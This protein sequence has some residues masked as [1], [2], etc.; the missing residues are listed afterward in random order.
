[1]FANS[2]EQA[3][4][5]AWA[6][7]PDSH[8][9][10]EHPDCTESSYLTAF[11]SQLVRLA[12]YKLHRDP[13]GYSWSPASLISETYLRLVNAYGKEWVHTTG[14]VALW[15]HAMGNVLKDD[16]RAVRAQKRQWGVR[17]TYTEQLPV[18]IGI[19][20]D[21]KLTVRQ[22]LSRLSLSEPRKAGAVKL[23]AM[24]GY[25]IEETARHLRVSARTV[26]R[27]LRDAKRELGEQL[28]PAKAAGRRPRIERTDRAA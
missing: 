21:T 28:G 10:R 8:S 6:G 3:L 13:L 20:L 12:A 14:P 24:H 22:S 7:A 16:A 2:L 18:T 5:D 17:D 15:S 11:Y 27:F 23:I 9:P 25:T 19:D 26:R 4:P 1:M